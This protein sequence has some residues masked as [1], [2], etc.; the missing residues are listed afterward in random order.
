MTTA[1]LILAWWASGVAI[2]VFTVIVHDKKL[3]VGD[4]LKSFVFGLL[5][6]ICIAVILVTIAW[7]RIDDQHFDRRIL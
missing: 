1:L 3:L 6:P 4:V 7:E 5:G 2:M